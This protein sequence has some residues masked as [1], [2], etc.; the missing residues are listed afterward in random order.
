MIVIAAS[1]SAPVGVAKNVY[2][3]AHAL[4]SQEKEIVVI[5]RS[6]GWLK[7]ALEKD[8]IKVFTM[9]TA[10]NVLG[11]L[12]ANVKIFHLVKMFSGVSVLHLNGRFFLFSAILCKILSPQIKQIYSVRQFQEVSSSGLF[13]WKNKLEAF[14]MRFQNKIHVVGHDLGE[15]V[16]RRIGNE[17][18]ID[19]IPNFVRSNHIIAEDT[20]INKSNLIL[21]KQVKKYTHVLGAGRLSREK[22]FDTLIHALFILKKN[23][24]ALSLDL[25][26]EGPE[27]SYLKKIV[28]DLSLQDNVTFKGVATDLGNTLPKYDIVVVPSRS[29]SFGLL[30]VESFRAGVAVVASAIPGL[31]EVASSESALLF[32]PGS[33][34]DLAE[35]I[36]FLVEMPEARYQFARNGYSRFI[37]EY[38][39]DTGIQRFV[40]MYEAAACGQ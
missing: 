10:P 21:Q 34:S 3:L 18:T 33:D 30:V 26:G 15:E 6:N 11:V 7:K 31:R 8:G 29:E 2:T 27:E 20:A 5:V 25:F 12:L 28:A 36:R 35:K 1:S 14:L 23:G 40:N 19:V 38:C 32:L 39:E 13:C 22:G 16:A 4:K 9:N 37:E 24:F 17:T